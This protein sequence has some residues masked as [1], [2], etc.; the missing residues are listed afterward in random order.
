MLNTIKLPDGHYNKTLINHIFK[1]INFFQFIELNFSQKE[2]I[3]E[4]KETFECYYS[5]VVTQINK[6]YDL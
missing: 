2:F 3:N 6:D 5:Y 1:G 4:N